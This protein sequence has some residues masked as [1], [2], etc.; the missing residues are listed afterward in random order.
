MN[1]KLEGK[2]TT[3]KNAK[4]KKLNVE[5]PNSIFITFKYTLPFRIP[6]EQDSLISFDKDGVLINF[7]HKTTKLSDDVHLN[8]GKYTVVECTSILKGKKGEKITRNNR[9]AKIKKQLSETFDTQLEILNNV[10]KIMSLK[11]HYH[12]VYKLAMGHILSIPFYVIYNTEGQIFN[13]GIFLVEMPNKIYNDQRST[14]TKKQ[15]KELTENYYLQL[16]SPVEEIA[17][18]MRKSERS[19][20]LGDYN[21]SIVNAQTALEVF[22]TQIVEN[23]YRLK[24]QKSEEKIKNILACGY[25]NLINDHLIPLLE[26]MNIHS[27]EAIKNAIN[28]YLEEFYNM[29]NRIVHR[30]K[31]YKREHAE[32]FRV[33]VTDLINM[34]V[35][36]ISNQSNDNFVEYIKTYFKLNEAFNIDE[37]ANKYR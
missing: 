14:L 29:R 8:E 33:I 17:A 18:N 15:M 37:V 24:I 28:L 19:N 32:N 34:I 2:F 11:F 1:E 22:V 7:L 10:I 20:Y 13:S 35:F 31:E 3:L 5:E 12:N 36:E 27:S 25:S 26:K 30:G 23:Y 16:N 4:Y 21:S 6:V 9:N